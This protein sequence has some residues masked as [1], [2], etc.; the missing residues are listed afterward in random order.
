MYSDLQMTS[1][2]NLLVREV[3]ETTLKS[4]GTDPLL[5]KRQLAEG[6]LRQEYLHSFHKLCYTTCPLTQEG[7]AYFLQL[8]LWE[9]GVVFQ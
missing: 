6:P 5:L 9:T 8:W 4:F 1:K 3:P 2:N 7:L